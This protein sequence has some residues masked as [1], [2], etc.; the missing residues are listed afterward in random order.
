MK[1]A[2]R[3]RER[4]ERRERERERER[5]RKREREGRREGE[6]Q[7]IGVG[8][9]TTSP[10]WQHEHTATPTAMLLSSQT[11]GAFIW[12]TPSVL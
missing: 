5:E 10:A 8:R 9:E 4:G 6:R 2:G 11:M 3:E 1:E 12:A 7:G